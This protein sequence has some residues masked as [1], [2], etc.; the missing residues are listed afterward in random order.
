M[1]TA[2]IHRKNCRAALLTVCLLMLFGQVNGRGEE[3]TMQPIAVTAVKLHGEIGRRIDLTVQRNMLAMHEEGVILDQFIKPFVKVDG[4]RDSKLA[5]WGYV[6]TGKCLD[7]ITRCAAY[8]GNKELIAVKDRCFD[9]LCA[10]QDDDGFIGWCDGEERTTKPWVV[11][12]AAYLIHALI[13]NHKYFRDGRSLRAATRLAHWIMDNASQTPFKAEHIGLPTA[14]AGLYE[15]TND[16]T[17]SNWMGSAE[18]LLASKSEDPNKTEQKMVAVGTEAVKMT[19]KGAA[20]NPIIHTYT[21]LERSCGQVMFMRLVPGL[22]DTDNRWARSLDCLFVKGGMLIPG[23][24]SGTGVYGEYWNF[25]QKGEKWAET[26]STVYMLELMHQMMQ[27]KS[28]SLYGDVMERAIYNGLFGAQDPAGRRL[29]MH[30]PFTGQREYFK[31]DFWCCPNNF[32]RAVS[33][34]PEWVYYKSDDGV[35]INLYER[36]SWK[37]KHNNV[38]VELVQA[39]DYPSD[40]KV[41]ITVKPAE[42]VF[43]SLSMRI[44]RWCRMATVRVNGEKAKEVEGGQYCPIKRQWKDGDTIELDMPMAWR[45]VKGRMVQ[46][47]RVALMRGPVLFSFDPDAIEGY[48]TPKED[49]TAKMEDYDFQRNLVLDLSTLGEPRKDESVRPN[50]LAVDVRG[51]STMTPIC[52]EPDIKI[53]LKE[54]ANLSGEVVYFVPKDTTAANIVDDELIGP[55]VR[56]W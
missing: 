4:R 51:W 30:V 37:F 32:R 46:A 2:L 41:K 55:N 20:G 49:K 45:W 56:R 13:S 3:T 54:F 15:A 5:T 12:E 22:N 6:G 18:T 44:P 35:L 36:S 53:P 33:E 43:F 28:D 9:L 24:S 42:S 21:D 48:V 40:G 39:T 52:F 25:R 31:E 11:H 10:N 27:Y 14:F 16:K 7:A 17:Y 26:C 1:S 23:T 8:S 50:G 29:C 19:I 34:L 47:G 38:D